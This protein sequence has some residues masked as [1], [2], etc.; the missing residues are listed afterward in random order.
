MANNIVQFVNFRDLVVLICLSYSEQ[1][2]DIVPSRIGIVDVA[3][4]VGTDYLCV[5]F[6][7]CHN[8]IYY[9]VLQK[10]IFNSTLLCKILIQKAICMQK[11]D[12]VALLS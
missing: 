11:E 5:C 6:P 2:H 1:G 10:N 3:E 12:A 8:A 7:S 4:D 9:Q